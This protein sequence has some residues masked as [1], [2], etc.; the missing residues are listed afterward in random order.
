[1][2]LIIDVETTG[3]PK[4]GNLPF[5]Q[6]PPYDDLLTY[7]DA[8]VV[9]V[10]MMLCNEQMEEIEFNDFV[11]KSDGFAINNS[12]FH[13]ITDEI[14]ATRGIPFSKIA[15][16][17]SYYLKKVSHVI[18]H[19]ANFDISILKSELYRIQFNSVI[20]ELDK[21]I[22]FCTMKQTMNIVKARY[23]TGGIKYPSLAELYSYVFETPIE[24][25]HNSKY[26]VIN[27]HGIVKNMYDSKK[28]NFNETVVY[29][30]QIIE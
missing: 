1:M 6:L 29:G 20:D 15:E 2:A 23:K 30:D 28:L 24:N 9:Q 3:L 18:A 12:T 7:D 13:G 16:I 5:G 14:S 26:D 11:V 19:N 10:S 17:L 8:R 21:K 22:I 25:A 27:L 4:R